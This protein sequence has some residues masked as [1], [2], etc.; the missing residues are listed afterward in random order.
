MVPSLS[1]LL[2][3]LIILF[4]GVASFLLYFLFVAPLYNPLRDV[5][6]PPSPKLFGTHLG[7]VL[8][9]EL[10]A[11]N[12]DMLVSRYG[13]NIRIR[14]LGP[15]DDR[16]LTLDPLA[17]AHVMNYPTIYQKPWQSRR[18]IT[19]LI[20]CGM[21]AAEG[22]VHKRQRKVSNPAFS[23][24][25]LRGFIPLF[26]SK[27]EEL[28]DKW[29][30]LMSNPSDGVKVDICHWI[31]R[32]TFDV[33]GIAGFDYQFHAIQD[34]SNEV[35][36]AYKDMFEIAISQGQNLKSIIGIYLPIIWKLF[37][38]ESTRIVDKSWKTILKVGRHL[39]QTKKAT[40]ADKNNTDR[41]LLT[42]LL[43]SNIS[44]EIPAEQRIS[45]DD[46]LFQISTF[47]FAGSDTTSLALTWILLLLS[48]PGHQHLQNRLRS[49]LNTLDSS[50]PPDE[51]FPLIDAL[52]FLDNV[53]KE[54]LRVIPPVHSSLRV[55]TK[56]DIIPSSTPIRK[57]DGSKVNVIRVAKGTMVHVPVEGFA[58]DKS[59]WG[60]DAWDFKPDRWDDLPE[61]VKTLPGLYSNLLAFSAG[62]RSCIGMRFSI[63]E[64]KIMLFVLMRGFDFVDPEKV[65]KAN[66][67]LTRPYVV[68]RF[69]EGSQ[70]PVVVKPH[71]AL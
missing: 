31:S 17:I 52:P 43:K 40:I 46:I 20:G 59:V 37:P 44:T 63:M 33:I 49:E 50:L 55:A 47:L 18:L 36:L 57:P 15:W 9:A 3:G 48:R 62:P 23:P 54:G 14:G 29:L 19:R 69:K 32:A 34:E 71:S 21:L 38:D 25:N 10:S 45:D 16:L 56:D 8:D 68:G 13:K 58:L 60:E 66:V 39:V 11:K 7:Y 28:R 1:S 51:L 42:L 53:I 6:G 22:V 27:A 30:S 41:D 61:A 70:C 67:V 65:F 26:F 12:H 5:P 64:M 35:Y 4:L 2:L 24:Q